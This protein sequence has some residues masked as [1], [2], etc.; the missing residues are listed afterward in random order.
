M[1]GVIHR[2]CNM[3]A[4]RKKQRFSISRYLTTMVPGSSAVNFKEGQAIFYQRD[5]EDAV[6]YI[7][8]GK[9]NSQR[10]PRP[11]EKLSSGF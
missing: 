9:S 11:V 5:T 10:S 1:Y 4:K 3:K 7:R 6:Y 8:R 2:I